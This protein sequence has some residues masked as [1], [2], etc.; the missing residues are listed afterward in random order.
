MYSNYIKL[1]IE[2][3]LKFIIICTLHIRS[4]ERFD[5]HSLSLT[6]QVAKFIFHF[7]NQLNNVL[8]VVTPLPPPFFL[9][10]WD[11]HLNHLIELTFA[12]PN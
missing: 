5:F 6:Q 4:V 3:Q 8:H 2:L 9:F 7:A 12:I 10:V 1:R 11:L